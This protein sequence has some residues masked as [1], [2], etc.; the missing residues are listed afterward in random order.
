MGLGG[1]RDSNRKSRERERERKNSPTKQIG[2]DLFDGN[3]HGALDLLG[4]SIG[5]LSDFAAAENTGTDVAGP[6]GLGV[7]RIA[8]RYEALLAGTLERP[9]VTAELRRVG[10]AL[11]LAGKVLGSQQVL[12]PESRRPEYVCVGRTDMLTPTSQAILNLGF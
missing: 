12:P 3:G 7:Q 11:A 8:R 4:E 9:Q 1:G 6:V 10:A 5:Q 2:H